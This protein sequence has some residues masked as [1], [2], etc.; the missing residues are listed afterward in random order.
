[1]TKLVSQATD[2]ELLQELISRNGHEMAPTKVVRFDRLSRE[3]LV[4]VG[5]SNTA[6]ITFH[7]DALQELGLE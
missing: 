1:M 2:L 4:A 7:Q 6:H 5:K 3:T